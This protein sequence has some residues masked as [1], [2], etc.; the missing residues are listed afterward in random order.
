MKACF[1]REQERVDAGGGKAKILVGEA[2]NRLPGERKKV[3]AATLWS[4]RHLGR[5][6]EPKTFR[7][8]EGSCAK[9]P[10]SRR[11]V[12]PWVHVCHFR[13]RGLKWKGGLSSGTLL[14]YN[15]STI[16]ETPGKS[17]NS[18]LHLPS[19][20]IGG[21]KRNSLYSR[22]DPS[23]SLCNLCSWENQG[24]SDKIRNRGDGSLFEGSVRKR[25]LP[26]PVFH[27]G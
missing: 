19:W 2:R 9:R 26:W 17:V 20:P 7:L 8:P 27:T 22:K 11:G 24:P 10:T 4:W 5:A 18:A 12:L 13:G 16:C 21:L 15:S 1:L 3:S 23:Q 6:A 14:D 25:E